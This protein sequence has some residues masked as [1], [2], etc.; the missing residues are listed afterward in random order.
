MDNRLDSLK[1]R[2]DLIKE[3]FQKNFNSIKRIDES[4]V[5][6]IQVINSYAEDLRVNIKTK[7]NDS[8]PSAH[9]N[10]RTERIVADIKQRM[11]NGMDG[12]GIDDL[13][14][15]LNDFRAE[16]LSNTDKTINKNSEFNRNVSKYI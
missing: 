13:K 16:M 6:N 9:Y 3:T 1:R 10:V 11:S 12:D 14:V 2:G 5:G 15:V 7:I 4:E 8:D